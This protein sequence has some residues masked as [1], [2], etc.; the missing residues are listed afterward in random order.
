[1]KVRGFRL[2]VVAVTECGLHF[3]RTAVCA[4]GVLPC[5][6][7]QSETGGVSIDTEIPC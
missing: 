1:M 2:Q 6:S 5:L 7:L 3:G 4:G